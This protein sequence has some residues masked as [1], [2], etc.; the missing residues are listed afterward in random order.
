MK[1]FLPA[2]AALALL[3]PAA[4]AQAYP[5]RSIRILVPF[6]AGGSTDI[7][8]RMLGQKLTEASFERS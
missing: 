3:L 7:L 1:H 6:A 2:L 5:E 4:G 8:A